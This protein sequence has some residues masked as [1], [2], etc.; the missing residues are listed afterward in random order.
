MGAI[1]CA[2]AA[3]SARPRGAIARAARAF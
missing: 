1:A 3:V 2:I